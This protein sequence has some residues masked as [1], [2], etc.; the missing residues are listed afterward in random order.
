MRPKKIH[1]SHPDVLETLPRRLAA[2]H[3]PSLGVRFTDEEEKESEREDNPQARAW[4][5]LTPVM[6]TYCCNMRRTSHDGNVVDLLDRLFG[7]KCLPDGNSSNVDEIGKD[8]NVD[9]SEPKP[10]EPFK[11]GNKVKVYKIGNVFDGAI[12]E[13][14][15]V[16]NYGSCYVLFPD[17]QAWF[18]F[19]DLEPYTEP[20]EETSPNV[21]HSDIDIAELVAKGCVLDPAKQFDNILKGSFSKERR[22]NI[23]A[24]MAQAILTRV[25]DTPQVIADAAFRHADALIAESERIIK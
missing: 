21:D 13:I 14:I 23:A 19:C 12:G 7:P 16:S 10:A 5:A 3:V 8:C 4:E 1:S 20:E 15:D 24:M 25:D 6:R 2:G 22:L 11:V 9:S 17:N 18:R